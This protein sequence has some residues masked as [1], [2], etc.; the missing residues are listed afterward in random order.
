MGRSPR[1]EPAR[2]LL[3]VMSRGGGCGCQ[4]GAGRRR[5]QPLHLRSLALFWMGPYPAA[6]SARPLP[7]AAPE[8]RCRALRLLARA[9]AAAVR[10][11]GSREER[12]RQLGGAELET[13]LAPPRLAAR[14]GL[15]ARSSAPPPPWPPRGDSREQGRAAVPMAAGRRRRV[16]GS[17]ST[18]RPAPP[19]P[20]VHATPAPASARTAP[21]PPRRGAAAAQG[22]RGRPPGREERRGGEAP[23]RGGRRSIRRGR[24]GRTREG[25]REKGR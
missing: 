17:R 1:R 25:G 12:E 22:L 15:R 13:V 8:G 14:A 4:P 24:R 21:P 23:R 16:R 19:S 11:L 18:A 2:S 6:G 9:A 3:E 20:R 5:L 10:H 7:P